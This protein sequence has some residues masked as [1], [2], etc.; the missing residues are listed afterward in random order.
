MRILKLV[1][2]AAL[3]MSAAGCVYYGPYPYYHHDHP[4]YYRY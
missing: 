4:H 2:G 3:L 1:V